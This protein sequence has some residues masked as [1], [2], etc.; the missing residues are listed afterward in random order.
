MYRLCSKL[1]FYSE[2]I[3]VALYNFLKNGNQKEQLFLG[4]NIPFLSYYVA[5][6]LLIMKAQKRCVSQNYSS[7]MYTTSLSS[8]LNEQFA[9]HNSSCFLWDLWSPAAPNFYVGRLAR[10]RLIHV[11][12]LAFTR[13]RRFPED[14]RQLRGDNSDNYADKFP[15]FAAQLRRYFQYSGVLLLPA[16]LW[17]P[18]T[19]LM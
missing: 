3:F 7:T 6:R 19:N 16:K 18:A 5:S 11:L 10:Y 8:T 15:A 14:M 12:I 9:D 4:W 13:E 2:T 1:S 17:F